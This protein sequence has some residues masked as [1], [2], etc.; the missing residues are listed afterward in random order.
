MAAK[1]SG[2]VRA[3]DEGRGGEES[4]EGRGGEEESSYLIFAQARP[5]S[6]LLPSSDTGVTFDYGSLSPRRKR[7]TTEEEVDD[8]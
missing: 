7:K 3:S 6:A 4:G 8:E 5:D 2:G 1:V